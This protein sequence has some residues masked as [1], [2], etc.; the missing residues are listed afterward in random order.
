MH[1]TD[2]ISKISE[3]L[4]AAE[5][6]F[7]RA[8]QILKGV[9][10]FIINEGCQYADKAE[11]VTRQLFNQYVRPLDIPGVPNLV[12]PQLD[13]ALEELLVKAVLAAVSQFCSTNEPKIV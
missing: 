5:T 4:G 1:E 10:K 12:E 13:D 7:E 11:P 9:V 3:N 2:M 8:G 6:H